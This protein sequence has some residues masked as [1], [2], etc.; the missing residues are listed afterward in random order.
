MEVWKRVG[1]AL[2]ALAFSA[3]AFAQAGGE[4]GANRAANLYVGGGWGQAHWRPGCPGTA[5]SCDDANQSVH[6][7]AGY[8]LTPMFAAEVAF[9]NLGK[10]TG[11]NVE[12]KG[13]AWEASALA[14]WPLMG[15]FSVYGR[16]GLYR[17]VV[18]GGGQFAGKT[19]S[20][21]GPTYGI[22]GQFDATSNIGVRLE[23]QA[24]P[25][26]GGSTITDSDVNVVK[27]SALWR[28]R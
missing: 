13:K 22:G 21:Y 9:T 19:E 1:A 5:T 11:T 7:F 8:Q 6:V 15:S 25:G 16:L 2:A 24:F 26:V 4:A 17:G 10:T 12:V 28:F 18:K 23:W 3:T 20:N 27:F 14:A